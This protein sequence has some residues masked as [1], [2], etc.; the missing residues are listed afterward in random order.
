[1][2]LEQL[3]E[4]DG[5]NECIVKRVARHI[6]I[7]KDEDN[8]RV[9]MGTSFTAPDIEYNNSV[10][11]SDENERLEQI[12]LS[13]SFLH[14]NIDDEIFNYCLKFS[15]L[16]WSTSTLIEL[17]IFLTEI[18]DKILNLSKNALEDL[19]KNW[20]QKVSL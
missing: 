19:M 7:V 18:L 13:G 17:T 12:A 9:V 14:Y 1:M 4:V 6:L 20:N 10:S 2:I 8:H 16:Q 15:L 11:A 3:L 5:I